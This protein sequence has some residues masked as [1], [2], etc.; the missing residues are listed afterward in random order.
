LILLT[1]QDVIQPSAGQGLEGRRVLIVEDAGDIRDLLAFLV[2]LEGADVKTA[3]DA[4]TALETAA[5][6]EFDVLLTDLGLPDLPGDLLIK[7]LR[8]MRTRRPR[9][10][11]VTGFGEPYLSRARQA[12]ADAVLVKP[13]EWSILRAE[14]GE[15]AQALVA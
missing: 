9:V 15:R 4:R 10:V 2:R 7:Q 6:W 11:V 3:P 1:H 12:G 5:S 8:S 13:L 14:L